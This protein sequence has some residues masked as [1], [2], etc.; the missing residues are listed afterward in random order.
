MLDLG[1]SSN[2]SFYNSSV[3]SVYKSNQVSFDT[4]KQKSSDANSTNSIPSNNEIND[5]AVISDE[6]IK[7]LNSEQADNKE[8]TSKT[9]EPKLLGSEKSQDAETMPDGKTKTED[10]TVNES[11]DSTSSN[12][13]KAK[14]SGDLTPEQKQEVAELKA[15]DAEVRAHEQ[16]HIAAAAGISTSAP[17]YTFQEGPD[18]KKYAIGGEVSVSVPQTGD[19]ETDISNAEIMRNAAMAPSDPSPQDR[20]VA[21]NA[22]KIIADAERKLAE[23]TSQGQK[24]NDISTSSIVV[25]NAQEVSKSTT[26]EQTDALGSIA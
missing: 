24:S 9:P 10:G 12:E 2:N 1:I 17:N 4:D 25:G 7:L 11:K 6:A 19:P 3:S 26:N 16:A 14:T 20:S 15:R 5:E 23:Q 22:A 8:K 18:G 13:E 21:R